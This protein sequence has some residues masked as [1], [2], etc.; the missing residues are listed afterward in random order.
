MP[1]TESDP[2]S[3]PP[4]E[5][6]LPP[7]DARAHLDFSPISAYSALEKLRKMRKDEG[8]IEDQIRQ[9]EKQLQAVKKD[10]SVLLKEIPEHP[11][12]R[13][14]G[15]YLEPRDHS[16]NL[17]KKPK[18]S[19][20]KNLFRAKLTSYEP[21]LL[22][23]PHRCYVKHGGDYDEPN[24]TEL[25]KVLLEIF[26]S[27]AKITTDRFLP[28]L[29]DVLRD[30][31]LE[32][33][34][35]TMFGITG[36]EFERT[37]EKIVETVLPSRDDNELGEWGT[38]CSFLAETLPTVFAEAIGEINGAMSREPHDEVSDS[39]DVCLCTLSIDLEVL[40]E[41]RDR[42]SFV[43]ECLI[44]QRPRNSR[45]LAISSWI[46]WMVTQN[47]LGNFNPVD[48]S[49]FYPD[50]SGMSWQRKVSK[51][52]SFI[53]SVWEDQVAKTDRLQLIEPISQVFDFLGGIQLY[54]EA[55]RWRARSGAEAKTDYVL[56][57]GGW[58]TLLELPYFKTSSLQLSE[59]SAART[60]EMADVLSRSE[61]RKAAQYYDVA[62]LLSQPLLT[63]RT[64]AALMR[65]RL[66]T[67]RELER[68]ISD[69][70]AVLYF[71]HSNWKALSRRGKAYA[72]LG[73]YGYALRDLGEAVRLQPTNTDLIVERDRVQLILSSTSPLLR[74]CRSLADLGL[75][76]VCSTKHGEWP[77]PLHQ[78]IKPIPGGASCPPSCP[79][80]NY[81]PPQKYHSTSEVRA[82]IVTQLAAGIKV[83]AFTLPETRPEYFRK[84]E[85]AILE[86][87]QRA[88]KEQMSTQFLEMLDE[89]G[90]REYCR[91]VVEGEMFSDGGTV[92]N[93]L[94]SL[95]FKQMINVLVGNWNV[96]TKFARKNQGAQ[97]GGRPNRQEGTRQHRKEVPSDRS[98]TGGGS[99]SRSYSKA[100]REAME[101]TE[102]VSRN[103]DRRSETIERDLHGNLSAS[104]GEGDGTD[105]LLLR[106][107]SRSDHLRRQRLRI[108]H[109]RPNGPY[110]IK[111]SSTPWGDDPGVKRQLEEITSYFLID[112]NW[113]KVVQGQEPPPRI[114]LDSSPS[115]NSLNNSTKPEV[116]PRPGSFHPAPTAPASKAK[117]TLNHSTSKPPP[118]P[119]SNSNSI[120]GKAKTPGPPPKATT[121]GLAGAAQSKLKDLQREQARIE[122][123]IASMESQVER[124]RKSRS[125]LDR[126]VWS[127]EYT[128]SQWPEAPVLPV[129]MPKDP[130]QVSPH[131]SPY[132]KHLPHYDPVKVC[133][134]H[135]HMPDSTFNYNALD[136][137]DY[138]LTSIFVSSLTLE[139]YQ[140]EGPLILE[141]IR[142]AAADVLFTQKIHKN[143]DPSNAEARNT[144]NR[145][146]QGVL[147]PHPLYKLAGDQPIGVNALPG[148]L[149]YART[150][151]QQVINFESPRD[152]PFDDSGSPC[153]CELTEHV[154]AINLLNRRLSRAAAV[155]ETLPLKAG[156]S[157]DT[158]RIIEMVRARSDSL[159]P[160][161]QNE[162]LEE[163]V[164]LTLLCFEAQWAAALLQSQTPLNLLWDCTVQLVQWVGGVRMWEE[165][166]KI[167]FARSWS[168]PELLAKLSM[169][170]AATSYL[171]EVG[172][173][174]GK[175][176]GS[177]Q[178]LTKFKTKA[179]AAMKDQD[180][181]EA[182]KYYDL[183]ALLMAPTHVAARTN[184][185]LALI[186]RKGNHEVDPEMA[187]SHC[188]EA[189]AYSPTSV[190]ALYRR[191]L[192]Y[193]KLE[194][195]DL[196][197]ED[198]ELALTY[199]PNLK[200]VKAELERLRKK[201]GTQD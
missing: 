141:S 133:P 13:P 97:T 57:V 3:P 17:V 77:A 152:D 163:N 189:L 4:L 131:P 109:Q 142:D 154:P 187:V 174:H 69:C 52:L 59:N 161:W 103:F 9:L 20:D 93:T 171:L 200:E 99:R 54:E 37:V 169:Y 33:M 201:L 101:P 159:G 122:K 6:V 117:P 31:M 126:A 35:P 102:G 193:E 170:K 56:E 84:L 12:Y 23:P 184:A 74:L 11:K 8:V 191:A 167:V 2:G 149:M 111:T 87:V 88:S 46:E 138:A 185:A 26:D 25:N 78:L 113:A 94:I 49:A 98:S 150:Q 75:H 195:D 190:K 42:L 91:K 128:D 67:P 116:T 181:E 179:D 139:I 178:D 50:A 19:R 146:L 121:N 29:L 164:K 53:Q 96:L 104:D 158:G 197:V 165:S 175:N 10:Q 18:S 34:T 72:A 115:S 180:Y 24:V 68:A 64:N 16:A 48:A 27:S 188:T 65:V 79:T 155:Q 60:K 148:A 32:K 114:P 198:L 39:G 137:L 89:A 105:S 172:T 92:V 43:S 125:T 51:S 47:T 61:P 66:D 100:E 83:T 22:C 134:P 106:E 129:G 108:D 151:I 82:A 136:S 183:L 145:I 55:K 90:V 110:R 62:A 135:H 7:P 156:G 58:K 196:A 157:V 194:F 168:T 162:K 123:E 95:S 124:M 186:K 118:L 86:L 153:I 73:W 160:R 173:K 81:P 112:G 120:N 41:L 80:P 192:A 176:V 182:L 119:T 63:A 38:M 199:E 45:S 44:E 132:L 40:G 144:I 140:V 127:G 15:V 5:S 70:T 143:W 30:E 21:P 1:Y 76:G 36:D 177:V 14:G 147:D 28:V 85:Y 107:N 130:N 166:R 71:E